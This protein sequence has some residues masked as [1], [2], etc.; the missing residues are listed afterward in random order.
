MPG[1]CPDTEQMSLDLGL[2]DETTVYP[3]DE[4]D[5]HGEVFTRRWVV[6]LILDLAGYT[7]DRDLAGMVAVEPSC[8]TGAFLI[9]MTERLVESCR[10]HGRP[11]SDIQSAVRAY[12]LLP[13]N[14]EL[15]Q[16]AMSKALIDEGASVADATAMSA[17][18]VR[19]ADFLLSKH[20][21]ETADFVLGNPPYI[22]LEDVPAA[23]SAAYRRACPTMRGRSDIFV[24]FIERGLRMLKPDGVLGF[25]VAD[26]WMHNQYGA[27]LREFISNG[28]SVESVLSMHD[29]DAFEAQVAA[30]PAIAVIRRSEQAR[31]VVANATKHFDAAAAVSFSRW[32]NSRSVARS[33]RAVTAARLP[34]WF[35]PETSWPAGNPANLVLLADL[36]RRF[37]PLEDPGTGTRVG[38]GVATGNDS[39]YLTHDPD[40]VEPDRLLPMLTTRDTASGVA[41]WSGTYMVNPWE[42]GRLVALHDYPRMARYFDGWTD[43]IKGR[44]VAQRNPVHWYRTIDRVDP[45]LCERHKLVIPDLKAFIHPVL[46]R[47]ETYP[48]HSFYVVTSDAWDLEVLGGVLLSDIA[49]LFV[50]MYCVRMRGGCYRFQAQYLRRIRVPQLADLPKRL[51]REFAAAFQDRDRDRASSAARVAY[52]VEHMS[53]GIAS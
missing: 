49:E 3:V 9:P 37:P 40:L 14:A 10:R 46:D 16:K 30:Y 45:T 51:S 6:E 4:A 38:I 42:N 43:E 8:G 41:R 39:V 31:A 1:S 22:R 52:G 5:E 32:V 50:A 34:T 12:D 36:E 25:I 23:R 17:T 48:H 2:G 19:T 20:D 33:T 18:C 11:L 21:I 44:H 29:V 15:A 27:H 28:Y 35:S 7:S 24:G 26:R 53:H 47:G 13:A